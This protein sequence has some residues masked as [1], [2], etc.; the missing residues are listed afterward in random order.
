MI[1]YCATSVHT[2]ALLGLWET[3]GLYSNFTR[4][5]VKSTLVTA[6]NIKPGNQ[7]GGL[8]TA[9][10]MS[11]MFL[12]HEGENTLTVPGRALQLWLPS[13]TPPASSS[14]APP[15]TCL[16]ARSSWHSSIHLNISLPSL[17]P[18]PPPLFHFPTPTFLGRMEQP[19]KDRLKCCSGNCRS[20]VQ[21]RNYVG[22]TFQFDIIR[23]GYWNGDMATQHLWPE[24]ESVVNTKNLY[25]IGFQV[26]D[27]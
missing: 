2:S 17:S 14:P 25:V 5:F 13:W 15:S 8:N 9:V 7:L 11:H 19:T 22:A 24:T 18:Q 16:T 21:C 27:V 26:M 1:S 4:G 3:F 23:T 20:A 6:V 10:V 12:Q